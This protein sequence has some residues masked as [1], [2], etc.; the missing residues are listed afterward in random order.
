[1]SVTITF[2]R[3]IILKQSNINYYL[4]KSTKSKT[5]IY[6]NVRFEF[7]NCKADTDEPVPLTSTLTPPPLIPISMLGSNPA[8]YKPQGS[9][10]PLPKLQRINAEPQNLP[11]VPAIVST[12]NSN[13][14]K[15]DFYKI[16]E[17]P[18]SLPAQNLAVMN[19][20][21][22]IVIPKN[23]AMAV[24]PAI[25]IKKEKREAPKREVVKE[26]K[27]QE[28][29]IEPRAKTFDQFSKQHEQELMTMR[30]EGSSK[31]DT[32]EGV[33]EVGEP[34]LNDETNR[35]IGRNENELQD[36]ANTQNEERWVWKLNFQSQEIDSSLIETKIPINGELRGLF[37]AFLTKI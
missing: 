25:T 35:E 15:S 22:Y 31:D 14:R 23:N 19:G 4:I 32:L 29:K 37:S 1:M 36:D 13:D 16:A 3:Y 10:I 17:L 24:Q 18:S 21:K 34:K 7:Q 11:K 30:D 6:F 12:Y 27:Q 33:E 26:Q 8:A 5:K 2:A 28:Q 20:K 9:L